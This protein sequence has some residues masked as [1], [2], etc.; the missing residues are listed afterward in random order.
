MW[1]P[2]SGSKSFRH[3]TSFCFNHLQSKTQIDSLSHV[4]LKIIIPSEFFFFLQ[5]ITTGLAPWTFSDEHGRHYV[6]AQ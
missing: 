4:N 3:H 5:T 6:G 2:T 1:Y